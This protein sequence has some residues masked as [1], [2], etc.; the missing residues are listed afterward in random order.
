MNFVTN[1]F[2]YPSFSRPDRYYAQLLAGD[3]SL[4]E[5]EKKNKRKKER[6]I[7]IS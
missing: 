4:G 2:L 3:H 7:K 6:K 1:F 5:E